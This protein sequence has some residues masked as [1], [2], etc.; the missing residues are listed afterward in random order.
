MLKIEHFYKKI[1]C[2]KNPVVMCLGYFDAVHKGHRGLIYKAVDYAKSNDYLTGCLTFTD[3]QEENSQIYTFQERK[4]IFQMLGVDFCGYANFDDKFKRT[5]W[6]IFLD[7]LL[8]Q[9]DIKCFYCGADFKF[10]FEQKG[11]VRLLKEYCEKKGI[12]VVVCSTIEHKWKKASTSMAKGYIADN[13][14]EELNELLG[15]TY[16][17]SGKVEKDRKVGSQ[18]GIPT[19]NV[20]YPACK[21]KL[22]EGVYKVQVMVDEMMYDGIASWGTRPTFE[23]DEKKLEVHLLNFDGNIYG[24]KIDI[25]FEKYIRGIIKFDSAEELTKQIQEDIDSIL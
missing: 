5:E 4:K 1:N 9:M 19:A 16:F 2:K 11:T 3:S 18:M 24:K 14:L 8:K 12:K 10:G 15:G 17:V 25:H 20:T 13:N 22:K 21:V 7:D 6:H 23:N